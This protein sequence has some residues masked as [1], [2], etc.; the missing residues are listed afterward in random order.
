MAKRKENQEEVA[1]TA[2]S[3]TVN[4]P[5]FWEKNEKMIKAF[6]IGLLGGVLIY[7]A[8]TNLYAK[9]Q[10]A[11]AMTEM[12][13]A[14]MLFQKDS[15]QLALDGTQ[16]GYAGF[17]ELSKNYGGAAGN[18]ANYYA[19]VCSL[20]LG[21]FGEAVSYLESAKVCGSVLPIMRY[22]ALGDAYSEQK[23][24]AKAASAYEN[25]I[26]A[27]EI[28]VITPTVMKKLAMLKEINGD[29]ASALKLYKDIKEKFPLT[30]DGATIDKYIIRASN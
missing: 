27:G 20:N 6:S 12:Y 8:Y 25:A 15:F 21:K 11:K 18:L 30:Q 14:E 7:F 4:A 3:V 22:A 10:Q 19:G 2:P 9:P 28:E 23:D 16:G 13:Q 24:M 5:S 29:K 17:A 1:Y 26:G